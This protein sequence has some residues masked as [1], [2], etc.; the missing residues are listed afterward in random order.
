MY[1]LSL[2]SSSWKWIDQFLEKNLNL[3]MSNKRIKKVITH[4]LKWL[5]FWVSLPTSKIWN[6]VFKKRNKVRYKRYKDA[7][8]KVRIFIDNQSICFCVLFVHGGV[9]YFPCWQSKY[10]WGKIDSR[11]VSSLNSLLPVLCIFIIR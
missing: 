7:E 2:F 6:L 3:K 4:D 9:M 1:M 5:S 8:K 11:K 10:S